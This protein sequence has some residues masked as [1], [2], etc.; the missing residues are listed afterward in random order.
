MRQTVQIVTAIAIGPF[1]MYNSAGWEVGFV[2]TPR[3]SPYSRAVLSS[4]ELGLSR[5]PSLAPPAKDYN[6][7][8]TYVLFGARSKLDL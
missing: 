3:R 7:K 1:Y 2:C 4:R 8:G 5:D 6:F